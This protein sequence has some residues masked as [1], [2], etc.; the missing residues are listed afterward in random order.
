MASTTQARVTFIYPIPIPPAV[1]VLAAVVAVVLFAILFGIPLI[2]LGAARM[3]ETFRNGSV[4]WAVL[5]ALVG[6]LM[7]FFMVLAFPPRSWRA[8]LEFGHDH[9][10]LIPRPVLRWID[11]P[12]AELVFGPRVEQIFLCRGSR[13][14][15]PLGFRV[16]L[17][18][19]GIPDRE[20]TLESGDN[21]SFRQCKMLSNGI[22]AA[23]G[24]QVRLI[25]RTIRE[26]GT[27]RERTWHPARWSVSLADLAHMTAVALPFVG[28]AVIGYLR[29]K[30]V[31]VL[32][33]VLGLWSL[34]TLCVLLFNRLSYQAR[35]FA[36]SDWISSF[37]NFALEYATTFAF[38]S[39]LFHKG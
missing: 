6:S 25:E 38:V 2:D 32:M 1:R 7:A 35:K 20:I 37:F 28:G 18:A 33:A 9:V 15:S 23:T 19:A 5:G 4:A 13:D 39:Y 34:Q 10:R 3:V 12:C 36:A 29:L 24:L 27:V 26:D 17:R 11:E 8:G 30:Y 31:D 14:N 21:L 22:A 16:I